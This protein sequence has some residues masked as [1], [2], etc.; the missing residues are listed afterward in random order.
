MGSTCGDGAG[1]FWFQCVK[2]LAPHT[3]P[4]APKAIKQWRK[5]DSGRENEPQRKLTR[6]QGAARLSADREGRLPHK[7]KHL[8]SP[9]YNNYSALNASSPAQAAQ[10]RNWGSEEGLEQVWLP[11]QSPLGGGLAREPRML[12]L[13]GDLGT[14][15]SNPL[16]DR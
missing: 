11:G 3:A 12:E 8:N 5:N 2:P 15:C 13:E 6:T 10:G 1:G 14:G 4:K 7:T 16:F 9:L